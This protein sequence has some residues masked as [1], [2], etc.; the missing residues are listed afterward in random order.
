MPKTPA[1]SAFLLLFA[2]LGLF[3]FSAFAEETPADLE[4]K[5]RSLETA[6]NE[7]VREH[8]RNFAGRGATGDFS[9]PAVDPLDAEKQFTTPDDVTVK[10]ALSEPDVRQPV[11]IN[12]DERGRM[13]VVQYLQYPFPAGLKVVKYD[14]HL[15][16]VFDK[17]P[18]APPHH[19]RG[20]DKIT[21]HEDVDGD[22]VFDKQKTFVDGLN[23]ATSALPG[24]GG[25]WVMNPPYLLFYPDKDQDDVPDGDPEVHL[26]GFGLADTH[27]VANSLTWGPDGW[28]YGAQG[29]TCWATVTLPRNP[30]HPSVHFKGQGIWRYHPEKNLFE[31]FAEGGGNT[32]AVEF[33]AQ[34]RVYSGHNGGNTRG[35]HYVQGGYYSKAWGKHGPLTNPYA[36]GFFTQMGHAAAERFSHTLVKYE[37]EALP[38]RYYGRLIAPVPLH[39][40]V[41][42]SKMMPDGSTW[43]TE[44]ELKVMETD[45]VWFRPVDIKT[46]PD[47]CVY[48]ADWCDTRL[49][50]VDPRDTWDRARG[51]IWR[52][53]PNEYPHQEPFDLGKL[54]TAELVKVLESPNKLRRQLAQRM[55]YEHGDPFAAASLI[56]K[57]P[58]LKGQLALEYLW[59]IHGLRQY[60]EQTAKIALHHAD[61]YVR[62]WGVRLL[63]P[64]LAETYADA[65]YQMAEKETDVEVCSQL[66]CTAKRIPGVVGFETA[67]RLATRDDLSGDPHIP[68]LT[69]WAIEGHAN[70]SS[71]DIG[72][73]VKKL[74]TTKI[75]GDVVLPRLAQ[76]LAAEPTEPHLLELAEL[77]NQTDVPTLRG[78]MLTGIDTAFAGR[79]IEALP[80]ELRDA[81]VASASGDSPEQMALLVRAGQKEAEVAAIAVVENEKAKLDQRVKLAQL[82]G[83]VGSTEAKDALLRVATTTPSADVRVAAIG[84]LRQF[85]SPEIA[86]ALVARYPQEN[87]TVRAAIIDLAAGRAASAQSLVTAIEKGTIPRSAV[88]VDLVE[89]LKLHG[90][91]ALNERIGK[92]W[93][94]TRATPDE[95]AKQLEQTATILKTG[96]GDAVHGAALFKKTC[97]TC[98]K[99]HG[100]G[101]S[102]GPEL[103]GYERKNLDYMLLSVVDPSA[104]IR[105]EYTNFRV[106]LVDGRVL[107]GFVRE[108]DDKTITLQNAE[109]PALVIPRDEIEE[110]PLAVDK[111]LMPDRLLSEMTATQIRD[112]FAYLQS[113]KAP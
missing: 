15:R 31:V 78:S 46:G 72:G 93:G 20:A 54:T 22:G 34:G 58:E 109:N 24:R 81:I 92:L 111:S 66:A 108:Q 37:S 2:L 7:A 28:L 47:G 14:E 63:T 105:E 8:I 106:L 13:W 41:A 94:A 33:D 23:I 12:F 59:A 69:W 25:V 51:R 49:T 18:P 65:L 70:D 55:I 67:V 32:F 98:H 3:A 17:V 73:I 107:S 36:F 80:A 83:Q 53:Q 57:L 71:L 45:D 86:M 102:I 43:K 26:A 10:L 62:V 52:I 16:A 6:E 88:A 82:L 85:D 4:K 29:S 50:H 89:N 101:A 103:T 35:F 110:G 19:D 74:Q 39:N 21:I 91:E 76:R 90:D 112:L 87:E 100:D 9:I 104:A 61:P 56:E 1:Y 5:K 84:G 75:G 48:V 38:A 77:L 40:Y 30:S 99:L 44:D 95:L 60:D 79:K 11:C 64:Q 42:V 96:S 97:A 68:L 27:A 113:D